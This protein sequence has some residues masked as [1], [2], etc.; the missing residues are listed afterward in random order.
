ML[1]PSLFTDNFVNDFFNSAFDKTPSMFKASGSSLMS[2]DVKEFKDHYELAL[3]L[4]GYKK[5]DVTASLKDGYLTIEA[6]REENND[7]EEPEH[8]FIR[9][10]RFVGTLTRSFYVGEEVKQEQIKAKFEN[11]VLDISVP[12]VDYKPELEM[13]RNILIE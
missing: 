9:R 11:G 7:T 5:E 2:A 6:K 4:P 10:E 12:K 13:A 3:E 1:V 8:R